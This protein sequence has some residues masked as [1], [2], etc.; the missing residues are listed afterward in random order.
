MPPVDTVIGHGTRTE[1]STADATPDEGE[2]VS[3]AGALPPPWRYDDHYGFNRLSSF[4][5]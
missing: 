2:S 1:T 4:A 5:Y 3:V